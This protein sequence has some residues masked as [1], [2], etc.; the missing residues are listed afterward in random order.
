MEPTDAALI[1]DIEN[2]TALWDDTA[3]PTPYSRAVIERYIASDPHDLYADGELRLI[4]ERADD[5]EA[6]G[7]VDLTHFSPRDGRAEV[8]IAIAAAFRRQGLG[9]AAL[10][11]LE[12]MAGKYFGIRLLF[13]QV[14]GA[15]S[16]RT[17]YK[18][19]ASRALFL[20]AD[21]KHVA[22][23]PQWRQTAHGLTD[24]DVFAKNL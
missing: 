9:R 19:E 14:A 11:A 8:S 18:N 15:Q 22:T 5:R 12:D 7:I 1:Y 2:D 23:L 13:A 20:S 4:A 24:V 16:D 6:V 10:A 3:A 17:F 21:Y